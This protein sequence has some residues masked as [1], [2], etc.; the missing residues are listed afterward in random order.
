MQEP[1]SP[2]PDDGYV[3]RTG[4][5]LL[6][7]DVDANLRLRLDGV[8]RNIQEVGAE[9]LNDCGY[10]DVH[11]H[12][13]VQRTVID[14]L[15]PITLPS[16]IVFRRWCSGISNRWCSMRVRLDGSDGGLI[17]TEG[18]WI[19]MN[20]ET[21]TPSLISEGLFERFATTTD[22]LR[23]KWRPWLPGP[24]TSE[25]VTPFALRHTDIDLFKHVNNTVYWHGV[26][27]ILAQYPDVVSAPYRAVVEYRKPIQPGEPVFIHSAMGD[28]EVRLWFVVRDE[29]RAAG[30]LAAL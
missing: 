15:V 2:V 27:E 4:W 6:T 17:E 9:H 14:V 23:L 3:Y 25:S 18:F 10:A 13:I 26:H 24:A 5:R 1:L 20:E 11:P 7:S 21:A 30:L 28:G 16:D 19:N 12:W 22:D 8:A 29:V